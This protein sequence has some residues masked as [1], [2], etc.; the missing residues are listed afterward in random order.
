LEALR[1]HGDGAIDEVENDDGSACGKR[2]QHAGTHAEVD[3]VKQDNER[4]NEL[5]IAEIGSR[6]VIAENAYAVHDDDLE[7][8]VQFCVLERV[9]DDEPKGRRQRDDDEEDDHLRKIKEKKLVL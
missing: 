7:D 5:I 9:I 6:A 2:E 4:K 8:R 3:R 1:T